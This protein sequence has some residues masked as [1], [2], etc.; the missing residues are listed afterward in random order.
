LRQDWGLSPSGE[1]TLLIQR[2]DLRRQQAMKTEC[3]AFFSAMVVPP[4][5]LLFAVPLRRN[6]LRAI[7]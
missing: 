7:H 3:G 2:F 6:F 5:P 1:A 4:H